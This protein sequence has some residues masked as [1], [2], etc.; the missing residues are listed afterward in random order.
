MTLPKNNGIA[1]ATESNREM[2]GHTDARMGVLEM[3]NKVKE[4]IGRLEAACGH[5]DEAHESA[6]ELAVAKQVFTF[7]RTPRHNYG[8]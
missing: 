3:L 1:V 5:F 8:F 6:G 4:E 2:V 7:A